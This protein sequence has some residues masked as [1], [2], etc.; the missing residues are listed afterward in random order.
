MFGQPASALTSAALALALVPASPLV[1]FAAE[2]GSA[3]T[4]KATPC[5]RVVEDGRLWD[6][7][8]LGFDKRLRLCF[9]EEKIEQ[10]LLDAALEHDRERAAR[11]ALRQ[12]LRRV[13]RA[14]TEGE[15]ARKRQES[16]KVR[17]AVA[18]AERCQAKYRAEVCIEK[19]RFEFV[20]VE[21]YSPGE[22]QRREEWAPADKDGWEKS[23]EGVW[24]PVLAAAEICLKPRCV[25]VGGSCGGTREWLA[26]LRRCRYLVAVR[27]RRL[28]MVPQENDS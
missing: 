28:K 24:Q 19:W 21:G 3:G 20:K 11:K 17:E 22:I 18:E 27:N 9:V 6:R 23:T 14:L 25:V 5:C 8:G 10:R 2:S 16:D 12:E 4:T 1:G 15:R 7:R 13:G 26:T